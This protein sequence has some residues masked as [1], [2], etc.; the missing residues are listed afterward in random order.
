M[1]GISCFVVFL[2]PSAHSCVSCASLEPKR[3]ASPEHRTT[4]S[5]RDRTSN[6]AYLSDE[7]PA[8][9]TSARRKLPAIFTS[10]HALSTS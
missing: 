8:L 10:S 6:N 9:S 2:L 4:V 5:R 3:S 1:L 7:D